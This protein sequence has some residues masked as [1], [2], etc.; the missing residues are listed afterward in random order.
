VIRLVPKLAAAAL[1]VLCRGAAAEPV[2]Y[3]SLQAQAQGRDWCGQALL[4]LRRTPTARGCEAQP[5]AARRNNPFG[6]PQN[7]LRPWRGTP[8]G[9]RRNGASDA[10]QA[11]FVDMRWSARAAAIELRDLHRQVVRTPR[12]LAARLQALGY[13][14][15]SPEAIAR[16]VGAAPDA[17]LR[18]LYEDGRA[19]PAMKPVMAV[20]A[21]AALGDEHQ[22]T[23][24][25]LEAGLATVAHEPLSQDEAGFARWV[26]EAPDRQVAVARFEAFLS[27]QGL[28]AVLPTWQVLRTATD[29]RECGAPFAVPPEPLWP[30]AAGALRI[31]GERVQ[32]RLG[33]VEAKSGYREPWTNACAGGAERSAHR[34]FWA[35]DLVPLQPMSRAELMTRL[36]PVWSLEGEQ[37]RL[38]LGFYAG[39]RFHVD[40]QEKRIWANDQG[41]PYAPCAADGSVNPL[42]DG[43]VPDAGPPEPEPR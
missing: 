1:L 2:P 8:F 14:G 30:N 3:L 17:E 23:D 24:S 29:W 4:Y 35:L 19:G 37:L 43:P 10:G 12:Q 26:S 18:L 6:A 34:E 9:D 39:V 27:R 7:P 16:A 32:P 28:L 33:P 38:G 21:Q 31:I 5:A 41:R 25:L 15:V 40:A 11:V 13:A 22:V 36:C 20:L 42:P